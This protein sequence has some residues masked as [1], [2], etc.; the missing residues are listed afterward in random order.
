MFV[1]I[2]ICDSFVIECWDFFKVKFFGFVDCLIIFRDSGYIGDLCEIC[3][4]SFFLLYKI[5][6]VG[7]GI[8]YVVFVDFLMRKFLIFIYCY[9]FV[10][11][12]LV[13]IWGF[14]LFRF[15]LFVLIGGM[16][17]I[18]R[19]GCEWKKFNI[20]FGYIFVWEVDFME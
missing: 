7:F 19:Y 14:V 5:L 17:F 18:E 11:R 2:F 10:V 15:I 6:W 9:V 12:C 13:D 4:F 8:G 20:E 1:W 3:V 16:G